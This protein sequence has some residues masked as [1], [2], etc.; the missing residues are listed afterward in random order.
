MNF[1]EYLKETLEE[2][3]VE[4]SMVD[5]AMKAAKGVALAAS[6]TFS[7]VLDDVY[8]KV[9]DQFKRH[10]VVVK[11]MKEYD[12]GGQ[13]VM[14]LTQKLIRKVENKVD[15]KLSDEL[16]KLGVNL[17]TKDAEG[18]DGI[19]TSQYIIPLGQDKDKVKLRAL[20]TLKALKDEDVET[21]GDIVV[22]EIEMGSSFMGIGNS[23]KWFVAYPEN[24]D[25]GHLLK[26]K[27]KGGLQE[28]E[29]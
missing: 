4:E 9:P 17:S 24:L 25:L 20:K 18:E 22:Q 10:A 5:D 2:G 27:M 29:D 26:T 1:E 16:L 14:E 23:D 11:A 19:K 28:I 21:Y 7:G 13:D 8:K 6:I 3:S 15:E 12:K